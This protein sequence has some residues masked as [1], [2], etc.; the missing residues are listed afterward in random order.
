MYYNNNDVRIEELPIPKIGSKDILI[1]IMAAGICGSD[2]ME[3][4]RIKKAPLVLGHEISGEII[5]VGK[6]IKKLKM[7]DRIF[8]TH[9]VPC[10]KCYYCLNG[11]HTACEEFHSKNN[12]DPGG[13]SEFLR[14]TGKSVDTGILKLPGKITYE[15][16]SF[17]E[18][19]GTAVRALKAVDF[20]QG[21]N[22]LVLGSGIIGLLIIKLAKAMGADRI[23]ATDINEYRLQAAKKFGATATLLSR[24]DLAQEIKKINKGQLADKILICAGNLEVCKQGLN[25]VERGGTIIFFAVPKPGEMIP[26]DFSTYWRNDIT[27]KTCYGAAPLDNVQALELIK[28]KKVIVDDMITHRFSLLDIAQGFKTASAAKA[29]LKVIIE[30]HK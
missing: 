5:E 11:H 15:Q 18:P 24:E 19:L 17:I 29:S 20:K 30:P 23:I 13:F 25:S 3:W 12:F 7:G 4:Y 28:T 8:A 21:N 1:K 9:H 6:E 14:I 10:E 2:I 22:L 27:L 26:I 16:A